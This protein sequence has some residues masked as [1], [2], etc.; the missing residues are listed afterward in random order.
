M[1]WCGEFVPPSGGMKGTVE[2]DPGHENLHFGIP[3]PPQPAKEPSQRS[4]LWQGPFFC[5]FREDLG[6][7]LGVTLE[8]L[9]TLCSHLGHENR[10][11]DGKSLCQQVLK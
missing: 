8:A 9:G 11:Y 1:M 2:Q 10:S 5:R 6:C 7:L 3:E 4:P